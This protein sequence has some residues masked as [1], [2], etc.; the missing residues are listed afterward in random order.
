MLYSL[1]LTNNN[2]AL[3]CLSHIIPQVDSH[4]KH[5][6]P[7]VWHIINISTCFHTDRYINSLD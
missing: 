6:F 5:S 1:L 3:P 7:I 2:G 4:S